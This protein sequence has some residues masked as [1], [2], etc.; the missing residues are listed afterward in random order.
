VQIAGIK[1]VEQAAHH[2]SSRLPV[3]VVKRGPQGASV[4]ADGTQEDVASLPVS[5]VDTVGAGDSFAAG[6]LHQW[7]RGAPLQTCLAYG[8]ISGALSVTR[9]GGTEAFRDQARKEE[10]F[11]RHWNEIPK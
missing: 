2:L 6:F 11:G 3:V 10:F 9:A 8:N 5:V 4:Y 7:I 1:D